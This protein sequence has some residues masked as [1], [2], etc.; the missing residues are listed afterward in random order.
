MPP[1]DVRRM[2]VQAEAEGPAAGQDHRKVYYAKTLRLTSDQLV[3]MVRA[4]FVLTYGLTVATGRN[5]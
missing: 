5:N 4:H 1:T 3:R 2:A